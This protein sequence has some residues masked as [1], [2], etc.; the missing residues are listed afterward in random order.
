MFVAEKVLLL[1]VIS[2]TAYESQLHPNHFWPRNMARVTR[3]QIHDDVIKW[4]HFP[5]YLGAGIHRS[6]VN[7]PQK[8]QWRRTLMFSLI[9]AWINGWINNRAAGETPSRLLWRHCNASHAQF[10]WKRWHF[11]FAIACRFCFVI[12][13]LSKF[14]IS[15]KIRTGTYDSELIIVKI[16]A[17]QS[18]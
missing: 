18:K 5:R 2:L 13:P 12:H 17:Y 3:L 4:K 15:L 16:K 7:S 11:V 1:L 14:E 9:S 6:P 10:F 8:G